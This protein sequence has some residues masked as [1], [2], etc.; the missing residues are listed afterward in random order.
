MIKVFLL[1]LL[2]SLVWVALTGQLNYLNFLFGFFIGFTIL[3]LLARKQDAEE[4]KYFLKVPKMILFLFF[5]LNEMIKAN[6]EVAREIVLPKCNMK[7][8]IVAF[9][10]H[11]KSDFEITMMTY[12]VALTPGTMVLKISPDKKTLFI[13]ALYLED[14]E[15][16]IRQME[17][18]L[19]KRLIE[20][21]R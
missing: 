21:I 11:L 8:G 2:L 20:I 13:H 17:N 16:F 19:E 18:G 15:K 5:Y 9:E 3:W 12:L 1:N 6:W 7:P 14:K 4:K 10:H